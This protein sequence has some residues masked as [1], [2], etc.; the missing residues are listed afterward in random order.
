MRTPSLRP[1][2]PQ[3]QELNDTM[4]G[5]FSQALSGSLSVDETITTVHQEWQSALS[6][7]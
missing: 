5:R 2:V 1:R 3:Y 7:N 6:E 4:S